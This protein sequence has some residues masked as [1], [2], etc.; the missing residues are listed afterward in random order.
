MDSIVLN[1]FLVGG[2]EVRKVVG[3]ENFCGN[4][5]PHDGPQSSPRCDQWSPSFSRQSAHHDAGNKD[6]SGGH[7]QRLRMCI[8]LHYGKQRKDTRTHEQDR[9][10]R[11]PLPPRDEGRD[12]AEDQ[13]HHTI[14]RDQTGGNRRA[15]AAEERNLHCE[16]Q[17]GGSQHCGE[18]AR[19][20][21]RDIEYGDFRRAER[22][23]R[24][25]PRFYRRRD[26][27]STNIQVRREA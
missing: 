12:Q 14:E 19:K 25:T 24:P 23:V 2:V 8:S 4:K 10:P 22:A 5:L 21:S 11:R 16:G 20:S 18:L 27:G 13:D 17:A 9:G 6:D 26:L 7:P 15:D 3:P 1:G